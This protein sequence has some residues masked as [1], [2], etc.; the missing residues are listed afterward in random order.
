MR[1][2][3]ED[4]PFR[5]RAEACKARADGL[6]RGERTRCAIKHCGNTCN[7]AF[8]TTRDS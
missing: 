5:D 2:R 6:V 7:M 4:R 8:D 3:G 1:R